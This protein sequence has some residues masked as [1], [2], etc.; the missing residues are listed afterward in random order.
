MNARL[1]LIAAAAGAIGVSFA[2]GVY[3]GK[4]G[5][6]GAGRSPAQSRASSRP[7]AEPQ[8]WIS[9]PAPEKHQHLRRTEEPSH[10]ILHQGPAGGPSQKPRKG[11]SG[12]GALSGRERAFE[13]HRWNEERK[14][15]H[16]LEQAQ[17]L[18]EVGARSGNPQLIET[19]RRM[20]LAARQHYE[21]RLRQI[22]RHPPIEPVPATEP[23]PR[24]R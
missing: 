16:Q 9:R 12:P 23:L 24:S 13:V 15:Q 19:A 7:G 5:G 2:A 4:G 11:G 18:R 3:A 17:H 1:G 8:T 20:E 14:L 10:P 21:Q 6:D 22:E